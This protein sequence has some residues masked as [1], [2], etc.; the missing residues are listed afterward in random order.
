M[1]KMHRVCTSLFLLVIV[2]SH[3]D[4]SRASVFYEEE[5]IKISQ[6]SVIKRWSDVS[7][8]T[9]V[10][11]CRRNK[12]CQH[13]AIEGNDCLFLKNGSDSVSSESDASDGAGMLS[14]ISLKEIDTKKKPHIKPG[15]TLSYK[16]DQN[17]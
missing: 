15:K 8:S 13:A 6:E 2:S 9:C 12:E 14:V 4:I 3:I 11:R 17:M 7:R 16:T 1:S 10:L 5:D